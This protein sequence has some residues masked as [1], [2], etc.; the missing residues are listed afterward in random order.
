MRST[1]RGLKGEVYDEHF[2]TNHMTDFALMFVLLVSKA[3]MQRERERDGGGGIRMS[4][5]GNHS[6]KQ[7][8]FMA[9]LRGFSR[10]CG[11]L[12]MYLKYHLL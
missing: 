9:L 7:K 8:L 12:Q 10:G 5:F 1:W 6:H 3:S 11:S 4:L 2:R